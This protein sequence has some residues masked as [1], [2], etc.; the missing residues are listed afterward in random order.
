MF[1]RLPIPRSSPYFLRSPQAE[2]AKHPDFAGRITQ[3]PH[4][5]KYTAH[6]ETTT[7]CPSIIRDIHPPES[8]TNATAG[9]RYQPCLIVLEFKVS[10]AA[11]SRLRFVARYGLHRADMRTLAERGHSIADCQLLGTPRRPARPAVTTGAAQRCRRPHGRHRA[12]ATG[13]RRGRLRWGRE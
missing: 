3:R 5:S 11:G 1:A 9:V 12:A 6:S 4:R 10:I 7:K 2:C 8:A 13:H